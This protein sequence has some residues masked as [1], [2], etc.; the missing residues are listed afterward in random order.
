MKIGNQ[1]VS[2]VEVIWRV[3][4]V[5]GPALTWF[6]QFL[7]SEAALHCTH[8]CGADG[9]NSVAILF[10]LV[11]DIAGL[12]VDGVIFSIHLMFTQVFNFNWPE[13]AKACMQGNFR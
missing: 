1:A 9:T 7:C 5:I 11:Y 13:S 2:H 10:S 4:K 3:D 12:F 6:Q 8:G